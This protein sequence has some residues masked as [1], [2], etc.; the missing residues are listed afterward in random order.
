VLSILGGCIGLLLSEAGL[1]II[2]LVM[3]FD[4]SLDWRA[5][6]LALVFCIAIGILFGSYPAGKAANLTPIEALQR[7]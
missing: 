2:G 5:A 1:K 4:L 3:D 7:V 6:T